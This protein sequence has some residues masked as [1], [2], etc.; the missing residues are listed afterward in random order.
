MLTTVHYNDEVAPAYFRMGLLWTAPLP[1]EP[2]QFIMLRVSEGVDPFLCRPFG[3]YR[4]IKP[5]RAGG[6]A[7]GFEILYKVVGKGTRRM[8]E[9]RA[10]E[11]V[12]IFGPLGRGFPPFKG[13]GRLLM[14]AGGVGIVPFYLVAETFAERGR[15]KLLFGG[16]SEDDLPGLDDFH[17]LGLDIG[18]ATEDGTAGEKGV[19]TTLLE[20]DIAD[21]DTL[22]ACGP[23]GMLKAVAAVAGERGVPCYVSLDRRMA[24]G[25]G[26]CLGCA[27][28]GDGG[29]ASS[30]VAPS[31]GRENRALSPYLMVCK[32]GPVFN[33]EDLLWEEL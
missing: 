17:A 9:M 3:V 7:R 19:V 11:A 33:A 5:E 26:A 20:R 13:K 32:D 8:S 14:V 25:M 30:A 31:E 21:N 1:V 22:Y 6:E 23:K 4:M 10:G 29:S 12:D 27:V 28:K 18:V 24:C 16:K 15:L 2:G